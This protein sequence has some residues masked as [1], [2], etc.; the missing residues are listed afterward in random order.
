MYVQG[1][2]NMTGTYAACLHTNQSRSYLNHLV[3]SYI[4]NQQNALHCF[5]VFYSFSQHVSAAIATIF[6]VILLKEYKDTNAFS[7][8]AVT[9]KQA[10]LRTDKTILSLKILIISQFNLYLYYLRNFN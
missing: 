10:P 1:G 8:I 4:K 5:Y 9:P 6:R 7:C 2:S 3:Y